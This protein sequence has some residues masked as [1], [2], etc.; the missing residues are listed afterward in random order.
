MP[1]TASDSIVSFAPL[2]HRP[3]GLAPPGAAPL[4]AGSPLQHLGGGLDELLVLLPLSLLGVLV[5]AVVAA[6]VLSAVVAVERSSS[7]VA[8][9]LSAGGV[10][11]RLPWSAGDRPGAGVPAS[12]SLPEDQQF[13]VELLECNDGRVRQSTIVEA[14]DWSKS[15]VSRLLST[16]ESEGYVQKIPVGRENVIALP[17]VDCER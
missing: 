12:S 8:E 16:M 15:K 7:T 2:V 4:G 17:G 13:V 5:A 6:V 9:W 3:V 14:S 10:T 11:G 1:P